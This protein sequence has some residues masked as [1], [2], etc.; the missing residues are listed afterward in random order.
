MPL[1]LNGTTGIAGVD[2]TASTPAVR[3]GDTNTGF[4][5][6]T[7]IIQVIEGGAE[8][9]RFDASGNLLVGVTS[10]NANG[11]VLQLKSGITFPATQVTSTDVNTLDDYEE[12]TWTPAVSFGGGSTGVTYNTRSGKYVKIGSL[13]WISFY[14]LL[15]NKGSST[16][17]AT[18]TG[19]PF[20]PSSTYNTTGNISADADMASMPTGTYGLVW[21]DGSIYFRVNSATGWTG[22]SNS[23]F[24]NTSGFYGSFTYNV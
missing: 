21:N 18:V 19:I 22:I 9:A 23:N 8:S 3:G 1:T 7:D 14:I 16:G 24:T 11:G 2:G 4:V 12:G 10:A 15:T 5:F 6:G 20:T 13:V 17:N